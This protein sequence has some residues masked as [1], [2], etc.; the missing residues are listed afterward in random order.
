MD[1]DLD[2][3]GKTHTVHLPTDA[4][5]KIL[6]PR[7][8]TRDKT[9]SQLIQGALHSPI[10]A[11]NF[12]TFIAQYESFL[13]IVNDHA[14]STPTATI[15]KEVLPYL[16]EKDF[17]IIVASGTHIQ[18][19][20]DI[21]RTTIFK[22]LYPKLKDKILLHDA[23]ESATV[24]IGHTSRG[25]PIRLNNVIKDFEAFI[26]I[27]S[28]EPHYFAGYTGGRKSFMPGIAAYESIESN[29]SMALQ[30]SARIL[31]L[32]GNPLHED[33]EEAIA[34]FLEDHPTF[35]INAVLDGEGKIIQTFA[36]DI[37]E[38]LY[39][40]AKL[41]RD[42][43]APEIEEKADILLSVVHAP[44]DK[45][46]YQA[47]KGLENC[48]FAVKDG[49]IFILI[50]E[51]KEGI[52]P[53]D[54][55]EMLASGETLDELYDIFKKRVERYEL[56]WHKVGSIPEFLKTKDFWMVTTLSQDTATK[57]H[58]KPFYS[59]QKA[60]NEAIMKKGKEATIVIVKDS[61]NIAPQATSK[62]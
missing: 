13:V 21:L 46:L 55:Q 49:G 28:I 52:G 34:M 38:Q 26:P 37:I 23:K 51:C 47:Q 43:Y 12:D 59:I 24:K 15:L 62:T 56:G 9:D 45:N 31:R 25:T 33:L 39:H 32:K 57:I 41:A 48:K 50:S 7:K 22:D 42:I 18:P 4:T 6:E 8:I 30:E 29:H 11:E 54:Y 19:T 44:L 60:V 40:G 58:V 3:A 20:K 35:A 17:K 16:E 10:N 36:G 27:N 5:V 53:P 61:G 2:Y 1:V 14:R